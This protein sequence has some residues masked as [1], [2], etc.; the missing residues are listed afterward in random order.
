VT[1]LDARDPGLTSGSLCGIMPAGT[2]TVRRD[3]VQNKNEWQ[4][5]LM[6]VK[7]VDGGVFSVASHHHT[8]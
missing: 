7:L 8:P 2:E 3:R 4:F 6:D 5:Q 1:A